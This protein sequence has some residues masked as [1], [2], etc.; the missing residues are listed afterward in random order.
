MGMG[1]SSA[2]PDPASPRMC[3]RRHWPTDLYKLE[4]KDIREWRRALP[5]SLAPGTIWLL[6]SAAGGRRPTAHPSRQGPPHRKLPS[7]NLA[8]LPRQ[9]LTKMGQAPTV[10]SIQLPS[11]P[12]WRLNRKEEDGSTAPRGVIGQ[13][14]FKTAL[15]E[16]YEMDRIDDPRSEPRV[17]RRELSQGVRP[18][19]SGATSRRSTAQRRGSYRV[20]EHFASAAVPTAQASRIRAHQNR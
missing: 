17:L 5:D 1:C 11:P 12:A 20:P 3:C 16:L 9:S 18:K 6:T 2:T 10:S 8:D 19:K 14:H 13:R 4:A 7:R 15:S